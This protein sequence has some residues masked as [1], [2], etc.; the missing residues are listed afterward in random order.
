MDPAE[1]EDA[2]SASL[3]LRLTLALLTA[4]NMH[5]PIWRAT[6]SPWQPGTWM[7][8]FLSPPMQSGCRMPSQFCELPRKARDPVCLRAQTVRQ[9][10]GLRR[11]MI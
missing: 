2:R 11:A 9:V 6:T 5:V 1:S 10:I 8:R 3:L 7:Q 4:A